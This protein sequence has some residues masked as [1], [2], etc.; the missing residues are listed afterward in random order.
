MA[1]RTRNGGSQTPDYWLK[2]A[3]NT[4]TKVAYANLQPGDL[5]FY[6]NGTKVSHVAFYVGK[7]N[8]NGT[9]YAKAIV[10]AAGTKSG[11]CVASM[12]SPTKVSGTSIHGYG[13]YWR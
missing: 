9:V 5:V 13:T 6:Y 12:D 7:I 8:Y 11:I 1:L 4:H 10:H 3:R 2:L